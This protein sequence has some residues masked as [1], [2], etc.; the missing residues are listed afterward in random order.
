MHF[1]GEHTDVASVAHAV[2]DCFPTDAG[3]VG[4]R[5]AARALLAGA[6]G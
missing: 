1:P 5:R 4:V 2:V 6:A 3:R